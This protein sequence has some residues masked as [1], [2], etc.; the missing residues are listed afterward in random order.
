MLHFEIGKFPLPIPNKYNSKVTFGKL[1]CSWLG[2]Y[3]PEGRRM[4]KLIHVSLSVPTL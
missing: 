1:Q 3:T 2:Y 4:L